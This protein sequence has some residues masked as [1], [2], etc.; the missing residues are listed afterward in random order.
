M[1][2]LAGAVCLGVGVVLGGWTGS[3]LGLRR[4]LY[5]QRGAPARGQPALVLAGPYRVMRHP[6][7]VSLLVML[8]G[9]GL[10]A[11]SLT[12]GLT[13][14][15]VCL[16]LPRLARWEERQLVARFGEAYRRYQG[17]VPLIPGWPR[18][19]NGAG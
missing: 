15:T 9:V 18:A 6:L 17:A 4:L 2:T 13:V 10:M 3:V 19:G 1:L 8:S 14:G 5:L 11:R 12:A 7:F 16:L